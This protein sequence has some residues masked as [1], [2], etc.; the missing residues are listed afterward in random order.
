MSFKVDKGETADTR[1]LL[2]MK[3]SEARIELNRARGWAKRNLDQLGTRKKVLLGLNLLLI[4]YSL[5]VFSAKRSMYSHH[6]T[7]R[8]ESENVAKVEADRQMQMALE[9]RRNNQVPREVWESANNLEELCRV[10]KL[11][12]KEEFYSL[13]RDP[14]EFLASPPIKV[15][16]HTKADYVKRWNRLYAHVQCKYFLAH[17]DTINAFLL[18]DYSQNLHKRYIPRLKQ[19]ITPQKFI[20]TFMMTST[21]VIIPPGMMDHFNYSIP[22]YHS[23]Q[24]LKDAFPPVN[25]EEFPGYIWSGVQKHML[26]LGPA[27]DHL[28][29]NNLDTKGRDTEDEICYKRGPAKFCHYPRN[30]KLDVKFLKNLGI[31]RPPPFLFPR[32]YQQPSIWMAPPK[33]HTS[34][35]HDAS[36][37]FIVHLLG[38]KRWTLF[39]P[40]DF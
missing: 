33:H 12:S 21:P 25:M 4:C 13:F 29:Q 2:R 23:L 22:E 39:P 38:V 32:C 17:Y 7:S 3:L 26:N 40:T 8:S 6:Q 9:S 34:N 30:T 18:L 16:P 20:E 11:D 35:H 14:E 37:N 15:L 27:V 19:R 10:L 1:K 36:D 31:T 24:E 5:F 28:V